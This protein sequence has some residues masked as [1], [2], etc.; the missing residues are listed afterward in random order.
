MH[1]TITAY[2]ASLERMI[3]TFDW[4]PVEQLACEIRARWSQGKH[5]FLC[6]NGGSAANAIHLANDLVYGVSPGTGNG[7]RAIALPA[8]AAVMTCIANDEAY[9]EVFAYQLSVFG[10]EGDLLIVFSG[11]GNSANI[12]RVLQRARDMGI[13]TA[14][15]LGYDGGRALAML[16][17]PLH[18]AGDDMQVA[19][20]CQ[21]I[22]G[23]MLFKWL[24]ANPPRPVP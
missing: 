17:L 21:Q 20:D 18:F 16:D 6:G 3:A 23:H 14:G 11:S 24:R 19:E 5:V 1:N 8:N 12:L 15:I 4:A 13:A 2:A 22:V 9:A 7:V 10:K